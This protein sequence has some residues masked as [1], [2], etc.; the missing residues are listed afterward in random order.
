MATLRCKV[1]FALGLA[2]VRGKFAALVTALAALLICFVCAALVS[3]RWEL[4]V[5]TV[6]IFLGT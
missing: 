4:A 3:L 1:A 5:V 2:L 6:F